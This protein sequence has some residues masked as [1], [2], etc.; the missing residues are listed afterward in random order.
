MTLF[1]QAGPNAGAVQR[2]SS[3]LYR[4]GSGLDADIVLADS[5]LAGVHALLDIGARKL[6]VEPL[7]GPVGLTEG[8][9]IEPGHERTVM[10]PAEIV[11]GETRLVVRAPY[12]PGKPAFEPRTAAAAAFLLFGLTL[13]G[14]ALSSGQHPTEP[15]TDGAGQA[16]AGVQVAGIAGVKPPLQEPSLEDVAESLRRRLADGPL[17][18]VA[19]RVE[20]DRIV[21]AG[22]VPA[23]SMGAWRGYQAWFDRTFA[24]S[25]ILVSNVVPGTSAKRP[26]LVI[27]AVWTGA[28]PYVIAGN[29]AKYFEGTELG[30][31]W[32]IEQI[33]AAAVVFGHDTGQRFTMTLH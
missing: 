24:G 25:A 28:V 17:E 15:S 29:D 8:G 3:G 6:R 1:V 9:P 27:R 21:A 10:L 5:S 33:D 14:F 32:R 18:G 12:D 23:G 26:E 19:V 31:G 30:D 7:N 22:Q 13:S 11:L 20:G 2:L 16:P 4:V